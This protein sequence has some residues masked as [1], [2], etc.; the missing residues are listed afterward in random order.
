MEIPILIDVR[1]NY[2]RIMYK[3]EAA[4]WAGKPTKANL[5]TLLDHNY[6]KVIKIADLRTSC[7]L[8]GKKNYN[9]HRTVLIFEHKTD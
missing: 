1:F 6:I 8:E 7:I 2:Y 4:E 9:L 3:E 5:E